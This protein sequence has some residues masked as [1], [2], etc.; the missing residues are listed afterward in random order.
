MLQENLEEI[1]YLKTYKKPEASVE[2]QDIVN[3]KPNILNSNS[4]IPQRYVEVF[5][6]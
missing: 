6:I 5:L 2:I 4:I 3:V 1:F